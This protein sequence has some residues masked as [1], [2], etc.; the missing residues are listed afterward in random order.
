M[1]KVAYRWIKGSFQGDKIL[2]ILPDLEWDVCETNIQR[3]DLS[4][5]D[6]EEYAAYDAY[7]YP[8]GEVTHVV[9][10]MFNLAWLH[11][12][13]VNPHHWQHWVL[14]EDEGSIK[15]LEMPDNYIL[16]MVCDWW[17]F[18]WKVYIGSVEYEEK[19]LYEIFKWYDDHK[20]RMMLAPKTKSKVE[21]LLDA[22]RAALD[23]AKR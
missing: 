8:K 10:E 4:K 9:S 2:D 3:H 15:P 11:H 7:F 16:E 13:H 5:H 21:R 12:I 17:S 6:V 19:S 22:I 1:V 18:S 23:G 14:V 20:E